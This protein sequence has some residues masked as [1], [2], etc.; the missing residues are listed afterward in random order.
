MR[1]L[2]LCSVLSFAQKKEEQLIAIRNVNVI[3]MTA[4]I[5]VIKNANVILRNKRIEVVNGKIPAGAKV[6]DGKRKWLIPGLLICT[7]TFQQICV[8]AQNFRH[9]ARQYFSIRRTL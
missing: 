7:F 2:P 6:I 3:P 4:D 5:D 1:L 9:K 8:S